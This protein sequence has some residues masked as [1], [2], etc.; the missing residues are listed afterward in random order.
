MPTDTFRQAFLPYCIRQNNDG[1]YSIL[2]RGYQDLGNVKRTPHGANGT[3]HSFSGVGPASLDKIAHAVGAP[4][5]DQERFWFL[6]DD[7]CQPDSSPAAWKDYSARLWQ[8]RNLR[9]ESEG[10]S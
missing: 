1:T 4:G 10:R 2:N 3:H 5:P 7:G 9:L 6:Y 8:L